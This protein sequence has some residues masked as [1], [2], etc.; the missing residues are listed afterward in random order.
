VEN[1]THQI[2]LER[3]CIDF[4]DEYLNR[5]ARGDNSTERYSGNQS[6]RNLEKLPLQPSGCRKD[7]SDLASD[8]VLNLPL[9][10]EL[11]PLMA[12]N[13]NALGLP[14]AAEILFLSLPILDKDDTPETVDNSVNGRKGPEQEPARESKRCGEEQEPKV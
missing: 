12:N 8:V 9:W 2:R 1:K 3:A 5:K 4:R 13:G 14:S 7:T 10:L 11:L 6:K